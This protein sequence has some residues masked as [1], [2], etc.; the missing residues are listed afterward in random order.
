MN[1]RGEYDRFL[2]KNADSAKPQAERILQL[3]PQLGEHGYRL[4]QGL[5][6]SASVHQSRSRLL[7]LFTCLLVLVLWWIAANSRVYYDDPPAFLGGDKSP[8][9]S[10]KTLA[11]EPVSIDE[12]ESFSVEHFAEFLEETAR[13]EDNARD[14]EIEESIALY[15]PISGVLLNPSPASPDEPF[16]PWLQ[17]NVGS[18]DNLSTIFERH[19]LN[20]PQLYQI[21]ATGT[22]SKRLER[23]SP[24]QN[25]RI[26]RD[27]AGN[28]EDLVLTLDFEH[29][30]HI[31]RKDGKFVE[32]IRKRELQPRLVYVHGCVE[33]SLYIDGQ[34][35]GLA[36][37]QI[38]EL[39]DIFSDDFRLRNLKKGDQ[40]T[41]IYQQYV[42]ENEVEIGDILAAEFVHADK[43]HYAVR[44]TDSDNRRS[45][46][47]NPTTAGKEAFKKLTAQLNGSCRIKK[48][49]L[50]QDIPVALGKVKLNWEM[51]PDNVHNLFFKE[52]D[53][54]ALLSW[55]QPNLNDPKHPEPPAAP[56][57]VAQAPAASSARSTTRQ[58]TATASNTRTTPS[59]T[60]NKPRNNNVASTAASRETTRQTQANATRNTTQTANNTRN[61]ASS[62]ASTS[63]RSSTTQTRQSSTSTAT[64]TATAVTRTQNRQTQP[65]LTA[66]ST[67]PQWSPV[68]IPN[69]SRARVIL[70]SA[71]SLLGT[72]YRYGGTSPATGFDCSGFVYYNMSKA[73]VKVPRT[74]REQYARA[75][76]VSRKEL[77][78]GDLVF[79]RVRH[80]YIDH[81][82]IYIGNNEFIHAESSRKPVTITSLDNSYY[83]RYFVGGGRHVN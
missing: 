18:G 26:K 45:D 33:N 24:E 25:L 81:V 11:R 15:D 42:F 5:Q 54:T 12:L 40:F 64:A 49:A 39:R 48:E 53:E 82:G 16:S 19:E 74:A 10:L 29:E 79:F 57:I 36:S 38:L 8:E 31:Y 32:E 61:N 9:A 17:V 71:R 37:H 59:T 7:I 63:T 83:R 75:K 13:E 68:E 4:E 77:K 67:A 23:L 60:A 34:K 55:I 44:L 51:H 14:A 76:P 80:S 41:L 69:D 72:R 78:P 73:G 35:A 6:S 21:L 46:Y 70:A 52:K 65:K 1:Q 66:K 20:K 43:P 30:L 50:T 2:F 3:S 27:E 47:Y 28:L 62:T 58:N 22:Y 56:V